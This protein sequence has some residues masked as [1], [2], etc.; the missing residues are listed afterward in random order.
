VSAVWVDDSRDDSWKLVA[1]GRFGRGFLQSSSTPIIPASV[2]AARV[3]WLQAWSGSVTTDLVE[4]ER[5]TLPL[6]A[7]VAKQCFLEALMGTTAADLAA[8]M[9]YGLRQ[10]QKQLTERGF[11]GPKRFL[12][13]ARAFRAW[14]YGRIANWS[15]AEL[16]E[17]LGYSSLA[18]MDRSL[19]TTFGVLPSDLRSCDESE[20]HTLLARALVRTQA[21]Q[22]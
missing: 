8:R 4:A 6:R 18:A 16:A 11:M 2:A 9:G 3:V 17:R 20:L 13:T 22:E 15:L 21:H 7:D 10:L 19:T 5:E 12:M 14:E 1:A